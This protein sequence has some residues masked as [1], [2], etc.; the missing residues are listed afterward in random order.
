MIEITAEIRAWID[1]N[2]G[3]METAA[4]EYIDRSDGLLHCKKCGGNRQTIVPRFGNVINITRHSY[5]ND[6]V[7]AGCPGK[8][9]ISL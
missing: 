4:D 6:I 5:L 2:T 7:A 3:D 8:E 1:K 9:H